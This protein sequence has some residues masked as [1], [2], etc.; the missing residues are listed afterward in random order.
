MSS[1][2]SI[3]VSLVGTSLLQ[4]FVRCDEFRDVVERCRDRGLDRWFK[5]PIDDPLN[6]YP[7]GYICSVTRGH[8]LFEALKRFASSY[9]ASACAEINGIEA[10]R[11][12]FS[13]TP[14]Q[15]SIVL[16]P[17][18]TCNS[19]LCARVVAEVLKDVH[20]FRG[21]ELVPLKS[22]RSV[23]E[24]EELVTDV[25][26]KVVRRVLSARRK[27]ARVFV[28]AAPGFK[29]E[30]TF[31]VI[32]SILARANAVMYI[33]ESFRQGVVLPIPPIKLDLSTIERIAKIFERTDCVDKGQLLQILSEEELVEYIDR[34]ILTQKH[35]KVCIRKWVRELIKTYA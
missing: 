33:H 31:L 10:I 11:D 30:T 1:S 18:E 8:E 4:N 25:L 6:R 7:D 14:S 29:A 34:G 27:G 2:T 32:A 26:D 22:V 21:V 19:M 12:A 23:D 15:T 35:E 16:L 20:G 9:G 17:T 28:N 13:L 5:L 3:I 24:F